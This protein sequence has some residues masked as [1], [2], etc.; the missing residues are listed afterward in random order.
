MEKGYSHSRTREHRLKRNRKRLILLAIILFVAGCITFI[1]IKVSDNKTHAPT[2]EL[3]KKTDSVSKDS[4]KGK[5]N[6]GA[7]G[8]AVSPKSDP[9]VEDGAFVEKY[10]KQQMLGQM[11]DGADGKKVAYLSFDDGPSVTVTPKILDIL[12][13]QKVK[14]T[15]FIVGKEADENEHTRNIIKRIVKEGHAIGNHTYSHNYKYLYPNKRVSTDHVMQDIERNNK[16]LKS[17]LGPEFTTRMIRFP[18]GHMTWNSRDPQ[19]MAAL[20]KVLHQ[21]DYHQ[22]DWNVLTKDAE[23]KSKKAPALIN[24]FIRSVKG[25]EKAI[26]LMHDTYGKEET[27]KALP[28]IIEF[29]KKQG[30]EF[31]VMK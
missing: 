10:L 24:Q 7:N 9:E 18:G 5:V 3:A 27:A 15:F 2:Q 17:I 11:P 22:V 8:K 1:A 30:Y 4:S 20:D 21:K 12:K 13:K 29:L 6:G 25:R 16:V 26:I 19:G 31:K 28:Q 14:A 23:G